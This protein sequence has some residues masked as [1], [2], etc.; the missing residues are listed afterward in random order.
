[1]YGVDTR[2]LTK[3]IRNEGSMLGKILLSKS[4]ANGTSL[5]GQS[6]SNT[7]TEVIGNPNWKSN[8]ENVEWLD[9]NQSNLVAAGEKACIVVPVLSSDID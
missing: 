1:M 9:P 3:K 5:D 4:Q 6:H 7:T 2:A 8:Y